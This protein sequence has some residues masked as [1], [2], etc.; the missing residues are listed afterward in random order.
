MTHAATTDILIRPPGVPPSTCP[1]TL[2]RVDG[3][4]APLPDDAPPAFDDPI[5]GEGDGPVEIRLYRCA[6]CRTTLVVS[7]EGDRA[8]LRNAWCKSR[9]PEP[10][11]VP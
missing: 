9:D 1:G 4:G 6:R 3:S 11:E 10:L 5:S 7:G 8:R 2:R